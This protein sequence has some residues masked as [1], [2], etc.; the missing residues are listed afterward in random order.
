MINGKIERDQ[1][2][3][4]LKRVLENNSKILSMIQDV[5][6]SVPPEG[7]DHLDLLIEHFERASE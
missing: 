7:K 2:I 6:D 5:L 1:M 4:I 3:E